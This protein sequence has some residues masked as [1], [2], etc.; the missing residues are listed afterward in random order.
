MTKTKIDTFIIVIKS[1]VILEEKHSKQPLMVRQSTDLLPVYITKLLQQ[2]R[3]LHEYTAFDG[4]FHIWRVLF[5][6][7]LSVAANHQ[8]SFKGSY[9]RINNNI[10]GQN[11]TK[12]ALHSN[13]NNNNNNNNTSHSPSSRP[14]SMKRKKQCT[15][16]RGTGE[17]VRWW[18]V[19]DNFGHYFRHLSSELNIIT[20]W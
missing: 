15:M 14:N 5:C 11:K 2:M 16:Q 4:I 10:V 7:C 19:H 3:L 8:Q 13:G 18:N 9:H 17:C 12:H 6:R 20:V 1:T